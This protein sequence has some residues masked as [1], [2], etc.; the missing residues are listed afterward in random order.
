MVGRSSPP[1]PF[2]SF[3]ACFKHR[4][5][6]FETDCLDVAALLAAEHVAGA[7]KFEI[8]CGDFEAGAEVA[9]LLERGEASARDVG[10]FPLGRDKQIGIG[11]A[12]GAADAS[13]KL[14]ELAEAVAIGAVDE[15]GVGERNVEA[16]L[17]DGGRDEHVEFVAHEGEHHAF[18][19]LFAHLA[20]AHGDARGGNEFL[21][22]RGDLVDRFDAIVNEVDLPAALEFHFDGGA[23]DLLIEFGHDGLNGHAVFGRRL[24]HAHVAQANERHVQRAR[25]RRSATWRA[26]RSLCAAA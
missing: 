3:T 18:E 15:H 8:E 12:I 25:D 24:D 11:A 20:V 16:V 19:F 10:Q 2:S 1:S 4:C 9:E 6:E 22:P 13:A 21:N 14:I 23:H 7:A 17:D 26:R 5:V